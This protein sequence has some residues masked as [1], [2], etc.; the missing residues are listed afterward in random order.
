MKKC[1]KQVLT[2]SMTIVLIATSFSPIFATEYT[3]EEWKKESDSYNYIWS[4]EK[5]RYLDHSEGDHIP[6]SIVPDKALREYI[7][8]RYNNQLTQQPPTYYYRIAN[9]ASPYFYPD[10]E[11]KIETLKGFKEMLAGWWIPGVNKLTAE[12]DKDDG[13]E[14]YLNCKYLKDKEIDL[15]DTFL[16]GFGITNAD[17][18]EKINITGCNRLK[19]F[20]ATS[21]DVNSKLNYIPVFDES[22][23]TRLTQ[24]DIQSDIVRPDLVSK[25]KDLTW[26]ELHGSIANGIDLS[27]N[28]KLEKLRL[29]TKDADVIDLSKAASVKDISIHPLGLD[30]HGF[31]K[32]AEGVN[33][34]KEIKMPK[35]DI[36]GIK[37]KE[38][39]LNKNSLP[40]IDLSEVVFENFQ[41][42]GVLNGYPPELKDQVLEDEQEYYKKDGKFVVDLKPVLGERKYLEKAN[43]L[44]GHDIKYGA[45]YDKETGLLTY[46]TMPNPKDGEDERIGYS[47]MC[48][49]K[50][51]RE[52]ELTA[53]FYNLK[54]GK[55]P[56]VETLK[57]E[58]T[59]V[60]LK[61]EGLNA[62]MTLNVTPKKD[63]DKATLEKAQNKI[64]KGI[65]KSYGAF[66]YL[67]IKLMQNGKEIKLDR[68]SE[69]TIPVFNG[70]NGKVIAVKSYDKDADSSKFIKGDTKLGNANN[71]FG[72]TV[73]DGKVTMEV[74]DLGI[75][76]LI[77][78]TNDVNNAKEDDAKTKLQN[79]K[80]SKIEKI[81]AVVL[82]NEDKEGMTEESVK[83]AEA[84]LK[85]LKDAAI[86]GVKLA[87][88][89]DAVENVNLP[90]VKIAK[91]LL[92]SQADANARLLKDAK[93]EK[94]KEIDKVVPSSNYSLNKAKY[95]EKVAAVKDEINNLTSI[96]DVKNY[97]IKAKFS[98]VKT[99]D[100][101][102]LDTA[103]DN[104]LSTLRN[105]DKNLY[106]PDEQSKLQALV[107]DAIAK[108]NKAKGKTE[109][110]SALDEALKGIEALTTKAQYE[111]TEAKNAKKASI[112]NISLGNTD[113]YSAKSIEK[114]KAKLD[115]L[116]AKAIKEVEDAEDV[117]A[118]EAV[119]MP[120]LEEAK[121]LLKTLEQELAE[122][123]ASKIDEI[124]GLSL[125]ST[126]SYTDESV[127]A[128]KDKLDELKKDALKTV[129]EATSIEAVEVIDTAKLLKEAK[130]LLIS[131]PV[132]PGNTD[133]SNV[134]TIDKQGSVL[135]FE[136]GKDEL[137]VLHIENVEPEDLISVE[138][139]GK[140]LVKGKDYVV[141]A[142]SIKI[143]FTKD[144]LDSLN[145]GTYEVAVNT[146]KGTV[147]QSITIADKEN[148]NRRNDNRVENKGKAVRTSDNSNTEFWIL[149]LVLVA[150]GLKVIRKEKEQ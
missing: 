109:V 58:K 82:T 150:I 126:S 13:Y 108:I 141:E 34:V 64:V 23:T 133:T 18:I 24:V 77:G 91:K 32:V 20:R 9:A 52:W 111:L 80:E 7:E 102:G 85:E 106:R 122:S 53:R 69:L 44:E 46:D 74:S 11:L 140:T 97:D 132:T 103:R 57:D 93:A 25:Q 27:N 8:S 139:D 92:E 6:E 81:N 98:D 148:A 120:N 2:L 22:T 119:K 49:D 39:Y 36:N 62:D 28:P 56:Q 94:I 33:R 17:N 59:G 76:G 116:K 128:A 54:E 121:S 72:H 135:K 107:D 51:Q 138:V 15:S 1:I 112:D 38:C 3:D 134:A 110:K 89:L 88:D 125:G 29:Y 35:Y 10:D 114:A 118:V 5:N 90:D 104:A 129:N 127:K 31:G 124:N 19:R 78:S 79:A 41:S 16:K 83:K 105:I 75:F 12:R 66:D 42:H 26:L 142:G 4:D 84:K 144:Y 87:K 65:P 137:V 68:P 96:D 101:M 136:K 100:E 50:N 86:N 71:D 123:K 117:T 113:G 131:N 70:L 60:E 63:I 147:K 21:S 99:N 37:L 61:G 143:K 73:K 115:E 145:A 149:M 45:K 48:P 130:S 55:A 43:I 146:K 67:D 30:I 14:F 47:L 95:D 40:K